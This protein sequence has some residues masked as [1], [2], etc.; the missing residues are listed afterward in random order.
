MVTRSGGIERCCA[1]ANVSRAGYYR[2]W[3]ASKPRQE[4]T[5][6]RDDIQRLSLANKH[7]GHRPV[8]MLLKRAGW[9]VNHKRVQRI[10]RADNLLCVTGRTFRPATTDGRHQWKIYPHPAR[11]LI[12][13]TVNHL[14]MADINYVRLDEQLIYLAVVLDAF[15]RKVVGWAQWPIIRERNWRLRR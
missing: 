7:H 2:H 14:W 4:E 15:S 8:T 12:A 5:A 13:T 3:Q 11:N 6:L 10:R 1:S 9:M